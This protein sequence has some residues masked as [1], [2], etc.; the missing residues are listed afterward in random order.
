MWATCTSLWADTWQTRLKKGDP[1]VSQFWDSIQSITARKACRLGI[2]AYSSG[3]WGHSSSHLSWQ[4]SQDCKC[5]LQSRITFRGPNPNLNPLPVSWAL[6]PKDSTSFQTRSTSWGPGIHTKGDIIYSN[7][8]NLQNADF[9]GQSWDSVG[10]GWGPGVFI[11]Y[12]STPPP[13]F[14]WSPLTFL[15][16]VVAASANEQSGFLM[17][18]VH[19]RDN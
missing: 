1:L 4:A 2:F 19:T 17:D 14:D 13:P 5:N 11:L 15:P 18:E 6:C 9:Q 8:K 10:L 7:H 3:G 16:H 12:K